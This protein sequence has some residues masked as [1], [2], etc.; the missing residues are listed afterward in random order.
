MK[1]RPGGSPFSIGEEQTFSECALFPVKK[2]PDAQG[3]RRNMQNRKKQNRENKRQKQ[4]RRE[5][6]E[7]TTDE[8][9]VE[10]TSEEHQTTR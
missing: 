7:V 9:P 1:E 8:K 3:R 5:R 2:D 6:R 10:A 4:E